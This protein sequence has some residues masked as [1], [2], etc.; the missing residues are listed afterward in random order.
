[1]VTWS[2]LALIAHTSNILPH[3]EMLF[4]PNTQDSLFIPSAFAPVHGLYN[5]YLDWRTAASDL[6]IFGDFHS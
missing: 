2:D 3:M 6:Y 4:L 5:S 1:M